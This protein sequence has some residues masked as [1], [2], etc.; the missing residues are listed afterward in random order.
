MPA[1]RMTGARLARTLEC[2]PDT[3]LFGALLGSY[4]CSA[5]ARRQSSGRRRM[6]L[7]SKSAPARLG[8]PG[9]WPT[10]VL[11]P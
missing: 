5:Q 2:A 4:P 3:G 6:S 9:A 11:A 10:E 1:R 7:F 8:P